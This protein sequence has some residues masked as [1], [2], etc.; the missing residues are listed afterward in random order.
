ME[1]RSIFS[2]F[3]EAKNSGSNYYKFLCYYKILEGIYKSVRPTIFKM[4][5][6]RGITIKRI[7][8]V[9]PDHPGI[10]V[11]HKDFIGQ[12]IGN[13]FD[14]YFRQEHRHAIAHF[15]TRDDP[16][17]ILSTYDLMLKIASATLLIEACCLEVISNTL[18][19]QST[20]DSAVSSK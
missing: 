15:E 3:R 12:P 2:L 14:N 7:N 8:E 16:P 20:L 19:Y 13:L 6:D 9:V 5:R 10:S 17:A 4:A 11:S 1:M 18:R